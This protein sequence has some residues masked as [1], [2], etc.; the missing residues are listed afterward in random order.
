MPTLCVFPSYFAYYITDSF[1]LGRMARSKFVES[2][3][4]AQN[5]NSVD[6]HYLSAVCVHRLNCHF[7]QDQ[8]SRQILSVP[9]GPIEMNLLDIRQN[10][11]EIQKGFD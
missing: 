2:F 9:S 5:G 1:Q 10:K 4:L 6:E 8:N 3:D 11:R 7:V